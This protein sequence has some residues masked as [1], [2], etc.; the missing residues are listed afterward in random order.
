MGDVKVVAITLPDL[1]VVDGEVEELEQDAGVVGLQA[2][3]TV[4]MGR[5]VGIGVVR[6]LQVTPVDG[7]TGRL[8]DILDVGFWD[9]ET[10]IS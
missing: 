4:A 8:A 9:K 1:G 6:T 3:C 5:V 7:S 10:S 2:T